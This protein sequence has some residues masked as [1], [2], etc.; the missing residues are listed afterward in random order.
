MKR[1]HLIMMIGV[2]GC[3]KSTICERL[4]NRSDDIWV[5][6]DK[7]R[8][9]LLTKEDKYFEKEKEVFE[10]FIDT[11]IKYLKEGKTVYLDATHLNK[12]SRRKV[13]SR[14]K[15]FNCYITALWIDEPLQT[16]LYRNSF[17]EGRARV[18]DKE[19][20]KMFFNFEKPDKSEGFNKIMRA[21]TQ[22]GTLKFVQIG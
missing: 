3:G 1:G 7:I 15:P 8:Y 13:L 5:S 19:V 22:D 9:S 21:T 17:R 16:C 14:V 2:P 6:R 20:E 18:P 12:A 11:T 10:I 4:T